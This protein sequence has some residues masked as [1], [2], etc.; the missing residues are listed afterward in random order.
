MFLLTMSIHTDY[1]ASNT[2]LWIDMQVF[3]TCFLSSL[4][5][6]DIVRSEPDMNLSIVLSFLWLLPDI[7]RRLSRLQFT[8]R[9]SHFRWNTIGTVFLNNYTNVR[10]S[11]DVTNLISHSNPNSKC[12]CNDSKLERTYLE[13]IRLSYSR[14]AKQQVRMNVVLVLHRG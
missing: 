12:I 7:K 10:N 2:C 14:N 13:C 4:K 8:K 11:I 5:Q 9:T 6:T 1:S 3:L